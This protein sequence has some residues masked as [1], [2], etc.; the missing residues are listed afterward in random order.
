MVS[1]VTSENFTLV[2]AKYYDDI[3]ATDQEFQDDL[4]RFS[5]IKRLF[6]SYLRTGELK[7][8]LIFNHIIVIYN[9]FGSVAPALLFHELREYLPQLAPFLIALN[10]LPER[11]NTVFTSTITLDSDVV[12]WLRKNKI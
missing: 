1:I 3:A 9:M 5:L 2:A 11:V 12:L 6:N 8:R 4:R 7:E 10:R